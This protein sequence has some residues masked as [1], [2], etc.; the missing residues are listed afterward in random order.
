MKIIELKTNPGLYS[1][2]SYLVLGTWNT[3]DDVNTVVDVGAD[4]YILHHINTINTGVGKR[5]VQRVILTHGH[6]DHAAGLEQICKRF[7][8]EV[9]AFAKMPHITRQLRDEEM[10]KLGDAQFRVIYFPGHSNDSICLYQAEEQILFSGDTTLRVLSPGGSFSRSYVDRL[11][12]LVDLPIKVI[13][14]GHDAPV[15]ERVRDMLWETI[16]NVRNSTIT[17]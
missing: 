16:K 2:K 5:P 13:Y 11:E 8:P 1:S 3:L 9:L 6:F 12:R 17:P 15:R 10:L 4:G 7:Q 14:S